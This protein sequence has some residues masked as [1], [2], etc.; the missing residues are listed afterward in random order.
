MEYN[1][2]LFQKI[3]G[4]YLYLVFNFA[5][6]LNLFKKNKIL[7]NR[8]EYKYSGTACSFGISE[9]F[10]DHNSQKTEFRIF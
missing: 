3:H 4:K 9:G 7:K 5:I 6:N 10:F 2:F 8:D 1:I